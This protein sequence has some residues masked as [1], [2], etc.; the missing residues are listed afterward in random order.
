MDAASRLFVEDATDLGVSTS[1]FSGTTSSVSNITVAVR[2]R[3]LL[4]KELAAVVEPK[5]NSAFAQLHTEKESVSSGIRRII[6]IVDDRVLIFD[7]IDPGKHTHQRTYGHGS[8]R[9]KEVRYGFD[10]VF[11]ETCSQ[12]EVFE[13]T[14]K[15]LIDGVLNGY[16]ATVFAYGATGCGKTHTITGTREDPGIIFRTMKELFD[17]MEASSATKI[18]ECSLSY[19]EVYNETIRDLLHFE[20]TSVPSGGL[21]LRE[22]D[23]RVVV[24]GLSEHKPKHVSDVMRMLIYGNENRT[25]A[26][27]EA[28]AV[29]SRS[30]AVLQIHIKQKDKT[31]STTASFKIATLSI[32]DLAGSERASV[33]KNKGERLLEGANINRD[34]KLTR[35]L[36]YSL[37][38][39]CKVV[40]ITNISPSSLHYEET[41][42]TLKYANRAK[43]IKTKV[44]QNVINVEQHVAQYPR[45]IKELQAELEAVKQELLTRKTLETI[46]AS[47]KAISPE[48]E[49]TAENEV[50]YNDLTRRIRKLYDKIES[51]EL[52]QVEV[53]HTVEQN[54]H[55]MMFMRTLVSL[56]PEDEK[57]ENSFF[58]Q[59]RK[60][61]FK[62]IDHLQEVNVGL[63]HNAGEYAVAIARHKA[64]IDRALKAG[65]GVK[66]LPQHWRDRLMAEAKIMEMGAEN[67]RMCASFKFTRDSMDTYQR[68]LT[69][70]M[71]S[72]QARVMIGV[73]ESMGRAQSRHDT[74][75]LKKLT[76][77]LEASVSVV[78]DITGAFTVPADALLRSVLNGSSSGPTDIM[79]DKN[80]VELLSG[81]A[82]NYD[83]ASDTESEAGDIAEE[84]GNEADE[85]DDE[86]VKAAWNAVKFAGF[87]KPTSQ[88]TTKVSN[89]ASDEKTPMK[90]RSKALRMSSNSRS[91]RRTSISQSDGE[92]D[93]ADNTLT[94]RKLRFSLGGTQGSRRIS[95]TP[96]RRISNASLSSA[97]DKMEILG[98]MDKDDEAT[99]MAKPR[100]ANLVLEE[101]TTPP[102]SFMEA[103]KKESSDGS[104]N[105][106]ASTPES[107][108]LA[109]AAEEKAASPFVFSS[110]LPVSSPSVTNKRQIRQSLIPVM[111]TTPN[112]KTSTKTIGALGTPTRLQKPQETLVGS[113]LAKGIPSQSLLKSG[114]EPSN[115]AKT[116][117]SWNSTTQMASP[118]R[119]ALQATPAPDLATQ[120]LEPIDPSVLTMSVTSNVG[121]AKKGGIVKPSAKKTPS[122]NASDA[123]WATDEETHSAER[124]E[125]K[126]PPQVS[127]PG[128]VLT[129]SARRVFN[130]GKT[131]V[132]GRSALSGLRKPAAISMPTEIKTTPP[133]NTNKRRAAVK[134]KVDTSTPSSLRLAKQSRNLAATSVSSKKAAMSM[135]VQLKAKVPIDSS[136]PA[137]APAAEPATGLTTIQRKSS[138]RRL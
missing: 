45:I 68:W 131:Q 39:N 123:S 72:A 94:A 27:T 73:C 32:I 46:S 98:E 79:N 53:D 51:K 54:E 30:H 77:M 34:S 52:D 133:G 89:T 4:P 38:G 64:S 81:V 115:L 11:S 12:Q 60:S 75:E 59:Y 101:S 93:E 49:D 114:L 58:S 109:H 117:K 76:Q 120:V 83:T 65:T 113:P 5:D 137:A 14:T 88:S 48:N 41:H 33:T 7:P 82:L 47:T 44:E 2:V 42:N 104:A 136:P 23:T 100:M 87:T 129:R 90:A 24:A 55:R 66:K 36:K 108:N 102:T 122:G 9:H 132:P 116:K 70:Q 35:L 138:R 103:V 126:T 97:A 26:P 22:D 130:A 135:E 25:K 112:Y 110:K 10:K 57:N 20:N 119:K 127:S 84:S 1:G 85:S 63:R 96:S 71:V 106:H 124:A 107:A 3:P 50:I 121:K 86:G 125:N 111:K 13:G 80:T 17:R 134:A 67:I 8:R 56:L 78:A 128:H 37:G 18:I 99:P 28:N 31:A 29:S 6:N 62:A 95:A 19:L 43:N 91:L 40:M 15:A 69:T 92:N 21:D 105:V 74:E 118:L 61:I 16:N